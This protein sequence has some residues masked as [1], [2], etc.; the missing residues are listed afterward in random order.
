MHD[1]KEINHKNE[2]EKNYILVAFILS[3]KVG[4]SHPYSGGDFGYVK[5]IHNY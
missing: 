1:S 4:Q 3:F 2:K 5:I